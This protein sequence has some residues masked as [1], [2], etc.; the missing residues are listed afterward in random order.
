MVPHD[1]GAGGTDLTALLAELEVRLRRWGA[2]IVEAFRSGV[3]PG[4]VRSVLAREGLSA[5]DD[6]VAWWG[7]HDGAEGAEHPEGPG[8]D[9]RPEDVLVDGWYVA[10]LADAIRIRRWILGDY[11]RIGTPDVVPHSWIPVLN[12][13]GPP[14]LAADTAA[15]PGGSPLYI[16]DGSA[17]MPEARP[18]PHFDS[19][20]ELVTEIIGLFDEGAF[21]PD[22]FDPR[23]PSLDGAPLTAIVRRLTRW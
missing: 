6:I 17:G 8:I 21:R 12:F 19:L 10:S 18:K 9:E 22:R 1:A 5:P 15:P 4:T 7:W 20:S 23:V 16:V 13:T 14:F 3:P 11:A 2:P